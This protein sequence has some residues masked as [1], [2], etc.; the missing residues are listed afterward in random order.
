[1]FAVVKTEVKLGQEE[2]A[3]V[4]ELR[5]RSRH[6]S[7]R[8]RIV[9]TSSIVGEMSTHSDSM[10]AVVQSLIEAVAD[11]VVTAHMAKFTNPE[12]DPA[13]DRVVERLTYPVVGLVSELFEAIG[14]FDPNVGRFGEGNGTLAESVQELADQYIELAVKE[15]GAGNAKQA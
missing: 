11:T 12:S 8:A 10:T 15:W 5:E 4:R 9:L 13:E 1:M 7:P 2:A 6:L 3:T 14:R